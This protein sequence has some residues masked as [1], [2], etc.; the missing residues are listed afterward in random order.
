MTD[1]EIV[2]FVQSRIRALTPAA[3]LVGELA[4]SHAGV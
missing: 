4:D 3:E 2:E 1:G